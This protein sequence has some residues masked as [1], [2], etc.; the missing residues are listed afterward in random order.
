MYLLNYHDVKAIDQ[1]RRNRALAKYELEKLTREQVSSPAPRAT[2]V[3]DVIELRFA[4]DC[5]HVEPIGA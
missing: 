3:A 2:P 1:Q 4:E 5:Q